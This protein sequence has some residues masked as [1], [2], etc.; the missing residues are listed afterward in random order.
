MRRA[1]ILLAMGALL[2]GPASQAVEIREGQ[3]FPEIP[4][5]AM[6]DGSA[7]SIADFRGRKVALHVF[8]SW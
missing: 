3:P 4:L 8:A 5:P 1:G 6:S 2:G 7:L